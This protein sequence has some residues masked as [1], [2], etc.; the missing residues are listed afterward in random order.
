MRLSIFFFLLPLF[1]AAQDSLATKVPAVSPIVGQVNFS[2]YSVYDSLQAPI[3]RYEK[4]AQD[5]ISISWGVNFIYCKECTGERIFVRSMRLLAPGV[6]TTL[7]A[8]PA[9]NDNPGYDEAWETTIGMLY[10]MLDKAGNPTTAWLR[11]PN[12]FSLKWSN[13]EK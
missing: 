6:N 2:N 13:P 1:A 11:Q 7:F 5:T 12:K 3:L 9:K 4:A 8:V 10:L